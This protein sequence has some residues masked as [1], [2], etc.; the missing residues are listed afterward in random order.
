MAVPPDEDDT[1]ILPRPVP[2]GRRR[3]AWMTAAFLAA[4][5]A[6]GAVAWVVWPVPAPVVAP[7]PAPVAAAVAPPV[8]VPAPPPAIAE[9]LADEAAILA[10]RADSI[11]VFRFKPNP[12]IL[13]LDFANMEQQG[14]MLNRVAA[15]VEKAGQPRERVLSDGELAE[16]I[17]AA[18]ATAAT[19]YYGHDYRISDITRFFL[20]ADSGDVALTADEQ[21]LRGL[22]RRES[23]RPDG[24]LALISIPQAGADVDLASRAVILHHELSHGEYFTNLAYATYVHRFWRDVM[25][26]P[27]RAQFRRWLASEGYDPGLDD[28]IINETQAYLMHTHDDRFFSARSVG[29]AEDRMAQL[30]AMFLLDMPP[31]WLRDCTTVPPAPVRPPATPIRAPRYRLAV[32]STRA[33][34]ARR[35]PRFRAASMAA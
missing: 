4:A 29:L 2:L 14:R 6:G 31:G 7:Q 34:A 26:E 23:G 15:L 5:A 8:A 16:A 1:V 18:G 17:R 24:A 21:W 27:E 20:L 10:N 13:V 28:L 30:Q 32:S 9:T 35:T 12:A 33:S 19:Y 3:V 25:R 22:V 11:S